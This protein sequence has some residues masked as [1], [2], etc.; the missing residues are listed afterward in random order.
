LA[1]FL[2]FLIGSA[3][4][5][6]LGLLVIYLGKRFR[7]V[8]ALQTAER[9]T[10][11]TAHPRRQLILKLYRQGLKLLSGRKYRRRETWETMVEFAHQLGHLPALTRLTHAAEI[12]AY[13]PDAPETDTVEEAEEALTALKRELSQVRPPTADGSSSHIKITPE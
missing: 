3:A 13:R 11:L 2:P 10:S 9:Y 12:A 1:F 8:L 6:G 4:L 7:L 5:V